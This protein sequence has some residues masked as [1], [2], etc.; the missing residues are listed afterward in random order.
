M[1]QRRQIV[2]VIAATAAALCLVASGIPAS[3]ASADWHRIPNAWGADVKQVQVGQVYTT[4]D[5]TWL[6]GTVVTNE[7]LQRPSVQVCSGVSCTLTHLPTLQ[8]E[9]GGVATGVSGTSD[10]DVWVVGALYGE[11]GAESMSWHWNGTK[12]STV[13]GSDGEVNMVQV[14]SV[15]TSESWALGWNNYE[16]GSTETVYH[17]V[18][19]VWTEV[20]SLL[21]PIF[22]GTCGE[23]YYNTFSD[24]TYVGGE[25]VVL[26]VCDGVPVILKQRSATTWARIDKGLP[27]DV[28]YTRATVVKNQLWVAGQRADGSVSIERRASGI[29][30]AVPTTGLTDA[31][32]MR[33]AAGPR[34]TV[35]A[36]GHT[37]TST[38]PTAASWRWN[39]T[40]WTALTTPGTAGT[41]YLPTISIATSGYAVTAGTDNSTPASALLLGRG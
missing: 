4:G 38:A 34:G 23:W 14:L 33:M 39:G 41:S 31:T 22:P 6:A 35:I 3:A 40:T 18:G 8:S 13:N 27:A 19:T 9:F 1:F 2:S 32:I 17:R 11:D 36:V 21:D 15:S 5:T 7:G 25:P 10:T 26:G 28:T 30:L 16:D 20:N 29:W 37:G 12:W 24:L